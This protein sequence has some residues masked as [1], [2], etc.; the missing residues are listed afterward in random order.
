M[1]KIPVVAVVGPTA[2]GKTAL[3]VALALRYRGEVVSADSMQVYCGMDIATAKPSEAE[4]KG[5]PHHLLGILDPGEAYS[6]AR[7]VGD[8]ARCIADIHA[9]GLLPIVCGGTGLYIDALLGGMRF[10]EEPAHD[11]LREQLTCRMETRG[12]EALLQE[13]AVLDPALA[14]TLHPND[15]GRILRALETCLLTGETASER[16]RRAVQQA[17]V[18]EPFYIGIAF[19]EREHLYERIDARVDR[20]LEAGLLEEARRYLALE[21]TATA[22]QAIGYKELAPYFTGALSL[23]QATENLKRETRRYAK[24]QMTWFRRNKAI[25]YVYVGR[26]DTPQ[27]I[28]ARAF[29]LLDETRRNLS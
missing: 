27:T 1:E 3:A 28:A 26:A 15:R 7:F 22:A 18:Y 29:A 24:R 20:M 13:L 21:H 17:S 10:E 6:V 5:V 19:E 9:R 2:S 12:S 16:R 14:A 23:A 4:K 25:H 11:A 8:A